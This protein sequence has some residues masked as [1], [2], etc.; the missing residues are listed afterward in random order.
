[1]P[2][3]VENPVRLVFEIVRL[4]MPELPMENVSALVS[5]PLLVLVTEIVPVVAE[6]GTVAV[7]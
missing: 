7:I 5:L 6:T 4:G 2:A 1:V 3:V